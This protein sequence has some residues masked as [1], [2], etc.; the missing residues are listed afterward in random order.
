MKC[1]KY[2]YFQNWNDISHLN[3][4]R[5]KLSTLF[6][7]IDSTYSLTFQQPNERNIHCQTLFAAK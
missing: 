1:L 7:N 5:K 3:E 2:K 6:G 4:I